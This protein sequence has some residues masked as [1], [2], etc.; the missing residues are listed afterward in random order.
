M[1]GTRYLVDVLGTRS[2]VPGAGHFVPGASDMVSCMIWY[3]ISYGL[4]LLPPA[5]TLGNRVC[6]VVAPLG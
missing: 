4:R 6:V 1:A 2:L 3:Q 5:T